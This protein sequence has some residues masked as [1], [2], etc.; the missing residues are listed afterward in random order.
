M[1]GVVH[2]L[3][4]KG[5]GQGTNELY[6]KA[7]PSYQANALSYIRQS[8][9]AQPPL[10]IVE[11]VPIGAGTGIFTRALL[12]HPEWSTSIQKLSALEPSAGMREVFAKSV[13][14][15]R[16][17]INEG[18]FD[19]TGVPD[20]Q[21][22]L[23][24]IAQAFHWCPDFDAASKEFSRILKPDGIVAL[25]WNLEDRDAAGWVG[26]LRDRIEAYEQGTPQFRLG[27]WREA[28]NETYEKLF[29]PPVEKI[30]KYHLPGTLDIVTSR[31]FSKS[32][33]AVQP[34]DVKA[35]IKKDI[36]TIVERGDGKKWI[37]EANGVFEYPYRTYVII[38]NRK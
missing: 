30:W 21:A 11:R 20:G 10:N 23:V 9:K 34:E 22:D 3:A 31:A 6:D 18:F 35:E 24:V 13:S 15:E 25:I 8:V 33:V 26:Q 37:D 32:Y 2:E 7:R 29:Q 1:S 19:N 5:F 36:Q 17:T 27:L 12:A 38:M 4:K 14:D 16:V 28:F